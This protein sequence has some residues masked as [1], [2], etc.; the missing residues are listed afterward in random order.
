MN[1]LASMRYLVALNEHRHFGRAA[2]ASHITQP[3]LSNALRALEREF[4]VLIVN[5]GRTYAGLTAEGEV[6][7]LTAQRM[8]REKDLL[9]ERLQRESDRPTGRLRLA[10]VPTAM[11]ILS[12]FAVELQ[13]RQPGIAPTVVSLSSLE[14]ETALDSMAV[15]LALGYTDRMRVRNVKL[16]IWPQCTERYHLVQRLAPTR[17]HRTGLRIGTPVTWAEAADLPLC[18]LTPEM[19]NRAIVDRAFRQSDRTVTPAMETNSIHTLASSIGVGALAGVLPD[20]ALELLRDGPY[21][22]RALVSPTVETPMGF[23]TYS[24]DRVSLALQAAIDLL[25]ASDWKALLEGMSGA[26]K[27]TAVAR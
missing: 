10:A 3:A 9:R 18:L 22:V 16:D 2:Q 21:E 7:L 13:A 11:P 6:V 14:I 20:S 23:M 4:G 17:A 12:R 15:D 26:G 24:T 8:L 19:H 5:R 1:L 25:N 27:Q